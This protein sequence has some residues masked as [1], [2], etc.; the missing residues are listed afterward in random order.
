MVERKRRCKDLLYQASLAVW[1]PR[2]VAVRADGDVLTKDIMYK[3]S[4]TGVLSYEWLDGRPVEDD[5]LAG[6]ASMGAL[7]W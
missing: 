3:V 6:L 5:V 2:K 1:D 4:S 7:A